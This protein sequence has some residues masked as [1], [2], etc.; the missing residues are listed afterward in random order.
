MTTLLK[1]SFGTKVLT[2]G[3]SVLAVGVFC[4]ATSYCAG[5]LAAPKHPQ[6][7][8]AAKEISV[9]LDPAK[10][11]VHWTLPTTLHTVHGTFVLKHGQLQLDPATGKATG[12]IIVDATSGKSGND[13]RDSK[14]HHDVLESGKYNDIVFRPE[15]FSGAILPSGNSTITL[16]GTFSLHGADHAMTLPVQVIFG[17]N[18]W[19]GTCSFSVP[20]LEW[21]LKNPSTFLLKVKPDVQIE[22]ESGGSLQPTGTTHP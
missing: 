6:A 17:E 12:E 21:G 11:A 1:K 4:V 18:S 15:S 5:P 16:K 2:H 14:M 10:T 22:F 19:T 13:S 9:T 7:A 8:A 3:R 20:F